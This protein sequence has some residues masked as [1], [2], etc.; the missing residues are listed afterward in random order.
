MP[1]QVRMCS[2]DGTPEIW[3]VVVEKAAKPGLLTM[4]NVNRL[5]S[6]SLAVGLNE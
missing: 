5:P 3:P 6:E 4:E 2:A 1:L